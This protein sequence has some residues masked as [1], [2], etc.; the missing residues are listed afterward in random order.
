MLFCGVGGLSHEKRRQEDGGEQPEV[1]RAHGVGLR[2]GDSIG[3]NAGIVSLNFCL[4]G[5]LGEAHPTSCKNAG[6]STSLGMTLLAVLPVQVDP[7]EFGR[8]E[9]GSALPVDITCELGGCELSQEG[10]AYRDSD[11][12]EQPGGYTGVRT[13]A[14]GEMRGSAAVEIDVVG[15]GE[16]FRVSVGGD[17][18]KNDALIF[19]DL[20]SVRRRYRLRPFWRGCG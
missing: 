5:S 20:G 14:E 11:H 9:G 2:D 6:S 19:L 12:T 3:A 7:E 8:E 10:S 17:Q 16:G 13:G 1:R 4:G 15:A 18:A